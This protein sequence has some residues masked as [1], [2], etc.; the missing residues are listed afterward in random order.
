MRLRRLFTMVL[1]NLFAAASGGAQEAAPGPLARVDHLVYAT[2]DVDRTVA[3]LERR[4]GVRA[5]PGGRDPA[6]GTRNALL[7]LGAR[8]YL[9]I[10]GPDAQQPRPS[11]SPWWMRD[12]TEPRLV[13]W[14]ADGADLERLRA[15]AVQNGVPL[16]EVLSGG[17]QRPDGVRITW[18]MT[19]PRQPVAD[20]VVPFFIDWGDSPHPAGTSAQGAALV[21]LRAEHPDAERVRGLLRR[22]GF[23]VPVSMG[24]RA[25]LIATLKGP[26]GQVELR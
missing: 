3:E 24:P 11:Q 1:P 21:A 6:R 5:T 19:S 10:V 18:R 20:G 26:R 8:S 23:E 16:G 22:V 25:A 4:L 13:A 9:E 7:A 15:A 2:P 14:A 12:L 17:R